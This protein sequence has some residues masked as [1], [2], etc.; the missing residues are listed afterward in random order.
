MQFGRFRK[1]FKIVASNYQFSSS[2]SSFWKNSSKLNNSRIRM[3]DQLTNS[4]YQ[5][6]QSR[7][8]QT[9]SLITTL[10]NKIKQLEKQVTSLDNSNKRQFSNGPQSESKEE[11]DSSVRGFG[12]NEYGEFEQPDPV[13][14]KWYTPYQSID[15]NKYD[16]YVLNSLLPSVRVPFKPKNGRLGMLF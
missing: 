11:Q 9:D 3:A 13:F 4:Q 2:F 14:P 6:F 12:K 10:Q 15:R 5:E 1:R 8:L 16:I 7:S